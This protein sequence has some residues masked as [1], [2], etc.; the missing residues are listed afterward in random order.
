MPQKD[1]IPLVLAG[2]MLAGMLAHIRAVTGIETSSL[3]I[4]VLTVSSA[5]ALYSAERFAAVR[6]MALIG[7]LILVLMMLVSPLSLHP[8]MPAYQ[9]MKAAQTFEQGLM[10]VRGFSNLFNSLFYYALDYEKYPFQSPQLFFS[11]MA[12]GL[13]SAAWL[14]F[15]S[16]KSRRVKLFLPM[17]LVLSAWFQGYGIDTGFMLYFAGYT[18]YLFTNSGER[19]Y[20][21]LILS[22]MAILIGI[23]IYTVFPVEKTIQL[24]DER[25]GQVAWLRSEYSPFSG[26]NFSFSDTIYEPLGENRLGG[27]VTLRRDRIFSVR[28]D[29]GGHLYLRGR[30]LT[31][32]DGKSW[33]VET[34]E[35]ENFYL[36][37]PAPLRGSGDVRYDLEIFGIDINTKTLFAPLGVAGIDVPPGILRRDRYGIIYLDRPI[38]SLE[39]GYRIATIEPQPSR[40]ESGTEYFQLPENYSEAVKTL[41]ASLTAQTA[42]TRGKAE[43]IREYLLT[44]TYNL[45][46]SIPGDEVDFVEHFLFEE[47]QGYCTYFA[48]AM[49]IMSRAAGIPARYVEG[50]L[51]PYESNADGDYVVTAD[52]AH[53]WA[54]LYLDGR[55][56]VMETTPS[57]VA[58]TETSSNPG[59]V[60]EPNVTDD[61]PVR[62]QD[63]I[64]EDPF[65]VDGQPSQ[66]FP[67]Y[68][69]WLGGSALLFILLI[70]AFFVRRWWLNA[71]N[72][73]HLTIKLADDVMTLLILKCGLDAWTGM[74]P[75]EVI[76]QCASQMPNQSENHSA[77]IDPSK[78]T[79]WVENAYYGN[80]RDE[81]TAASLKQFRDDF[82][83]GERNWVKKCR[84]LYWIY[85]KGE[86]STWS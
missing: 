58:E 71:Q 1:R 21:G 30:V 76:Y 26:G 68:G 60:L 36:D 16:P 9:A 42:D 64:E 5:L 85:L 37:Q 44:L 29:H 79:G 62:P 69:I 77:G 17:V 48:S 33:Q 11:L 18:G 31:V 86:R 24:L 40:L 34:G 57:Y 46:P 54:E 53:A 3:F 55:W 51:T 78:L 28:S 23:G 4:A 74:T 2:L 82:V 6:V 45:S 70:L 80:Y 75:K 83:K 67:A 39:N 14:I 13:T 52:R 22:G 61:L 25:F 72:E 63:D 20:S 35:F 8:L 50:F 43:A 84:Y 59:P 49:V 38:E 66:R 65:E 32:Y 47:Q 15:R 41:T 73:L 10:G 81:L 19:G 56:T 12:W 27:P 7:S